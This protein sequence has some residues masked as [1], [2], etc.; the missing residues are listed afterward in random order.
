MRLDFGNEIERMDLM[1]T[2]MMKRK[3]CERVISE[4][5]GVCCGR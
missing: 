3:R 5:E 4:D 2:L 1:M